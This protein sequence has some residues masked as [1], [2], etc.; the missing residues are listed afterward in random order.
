MKYKGKEIGIPS[1]EQIEECCREEKLHVPAIEVYHYYSKKNWL[2]GKHKPVKTLE[3][4]CSAVNGAFLKRL[5]KNEPFLPTYDGMSNNISKNED[6]LTIIRDYFESKAELTI[7]CLEVL[8]A[9]NPPLF[10]EVYYELH[11]LGFTSLQP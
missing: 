9:A 7:K 10:A 1:L 4:A 5:R 6:E 8:K 3:A 2:T 11:E